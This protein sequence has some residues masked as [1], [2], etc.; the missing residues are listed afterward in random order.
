MFEKPLKFPLKIAQ[1]ETLKKHYPSIELD[2][3]I[4][5][6]KIGFAGEKAISYYLQSNYFEDV[7]I[8]H[9]VRLK[10]KNQICQIDFLL[11]TQSFILL[12]E[13]KNIHGTLTLEDTNGQFIKNTKHTEKAFMNPIDQV[14]KQ[15]DLLSLFL[16]E[17]GFPFIPI[18]TNVVI[19]QPSTILKITNTDDAKKFIYGY[20]LENHFKKLTT[21]YQQSIYSVKKLNQLSKVLLHSIQELSMNWSKRFAITSED[22]KRGIFCSNCKQFSMNY[23]YG[24]CICKHCNNSDSLAAI[25]ALEEYYYLFGEYM[26]TNDCRDWLGLYSDKI[27]RRLLKEFSVEFV[28]STKKKIYKLDKGKILKHSKYLY[29]YY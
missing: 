8:F 13:C 2:E 9:D 6:F 3:M 20:Q 10:W 7:K 14:Q 12:L 24:K 18:V 22:L 17:H 23:Y 19:A 29:P 25:H 4:Q 1:L 21:Y 5:S 27:A 16:Q 28:G 15:A 26:S 11:L